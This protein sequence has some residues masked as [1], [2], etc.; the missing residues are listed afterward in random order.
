MI[1]Q[2]HKPIGPRGFTLAELAIVLLI[3]GLLLGG[4]L[5]PLGTQVDLR[6]DAAAQKS[7]EEIR[8]ALL[9]YAVAN[10]R[11]PCPDTDMDGLEN[12]NAVVVDSTPAPGQSTQTITCVSDEGNLPYQNL[13]VGREDQWGNLFRYRASPSFT[14][15]TIVWSGLGATGTTVS[16]T[17]FT[18]ASTGNITVTTRGDNP[19]TA[20]TV[21]SKF[22]LNLTTSAPA[23]VLSFGKNSYGA[24]K[25]GGGALAAPP[26]SHADEIV[27]SNNGTTK[28]S[29]TRTS[30]QAGCNDS[31]EGQPFCEFDD[32]VMWLPTT[33]LFSR[34]VAAGRLP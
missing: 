32:L 15:T 33:I 21:E 10:R 28:A 13:G 29:R 3:I 14:T 27:N 23:V 11:L 25:A 24:T 6:R 17:S 18:L 19:A 16:T 7:L 9:G 1:R 30:D 4:L 34:M 2:A 5:L 12:V 31:I 22:S 20:G 8:E 26:A